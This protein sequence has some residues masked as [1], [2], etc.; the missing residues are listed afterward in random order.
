MTLCK[1]N[2]IENNLKLKNRKQ[3][4]KE[5]QYSL[6][7][8][9]YNLYKFCSTNRIAIQSAVPVLYKCFPTP[10]PFAVGDR[11]PCVTQCFLES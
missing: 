1:P 11:N 2:L 4:A 8:C 5:E 9:A 7:Q 6:V 10:L 3:T